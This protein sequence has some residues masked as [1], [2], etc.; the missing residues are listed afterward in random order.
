V[1]SSNARSFDVVE[2]LRKIVSNLELAMD[3]RKT[4]PTFSVYMM[5]G[6]LCQSGKTAIIFI[7][8]LIA[9]WYQVPHIC[10]SHYVVGRKDT[11]SKLLKI[12]A[13]IQSTGYWDKHFIMDC[14]TGRS[15][16]AKQ[17][18]IEGMAE[19]A[20]IVVNDTGAALEKVQGMLWQYFGKQSGNTNSCPREHI[21]SF[22]MTIDEADT[23]FRSPGDSL[24]TRLE[25]AIDNL[26][27]NK[28]E[29]PLIVMDISGTLA[30]NLYKLKNPVDFTDRNIIFTRP[31]DDYV[32]ANMVKPFTDVDGRYALAGHIAVLVSFASLCP[33]DASS[34]TT[35]S[36]STTHCVCL[37]AAETCS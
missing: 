2:A 14:V 15:E 30:P 32:G 1:C 6:G 26:I 18:V 11:L 17:A 33:V 34:H 19:G 25:R 28:K 20:T 22:I 24:D 13:R 23:R 37:A 3:K 31:G 8:S 9:R 35:V 7:I 4:D 29:P 36:D 12:L 27:H 10:L 5:A 21:H 16:K